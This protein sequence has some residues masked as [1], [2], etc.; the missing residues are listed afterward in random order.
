MGV[1]VCGCVGVWVCGCVVASS[2]APCG[3]VGSDVLVMGV[4]HSDLEVHERARAGDVQAVRKLLGGGWRG[5]RG[6]RVLVACAPGRGADGGHLGAHGLV[7]VRDAGG[8]AALHYAGMGGSVAVARE[9]LRCGAFPMVT[10]RAGTTAAHC[11]AG[12]GHAEVLRVL[13][14]AAPSLASAAG[15]EAGYT[16]LHWACYAGHRDAASVLLLAGAAEN[17]QSASGRT[18]LHLAS[19]FGHAD[20]AGLLCNGGADPGLPDVAGRTS[21]EYALLG[22]ETKG[23]AS[24]GQ[25]AA[26]GLTPADAEALSRELYVECSALLDPLL[27]QQ[28]RAVD[29]AEV[30]AAQQQ[31]QAQQQHQQRQRQRQRHRQRQRGESGRRLRPDPSIPLHT[32]AH[33][34]P[35]VDPATLRRA[36]VAILNPAAFRASAELARPRAGRPG[37]AGGDEG[38]E[39]DEGEGEGEGDEGGEGVTQGASEEEPDYEGKYPCSVCLGA[40]KEAA[41]MPCGHLCVCVACGKRIATENC[42]CPI[43]RR[44]VSAVLRIYL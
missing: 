19:F 25:L 28:I 21:S 8:W 44:P 2:R 11:A 22:L 38:D 20:V 5:R 26:A 37:R 29:A 41:T 3:V 33:P 10:N 13:L 40:P 34:G 36:D 4:A 6:W 24:R 15:A 39:G 14:E 42:G 9:L 1:W 32:V 43:C 30:A 35:G 23:I 31:E 12:F 27:S 16:P 17:A 7:D 18:P